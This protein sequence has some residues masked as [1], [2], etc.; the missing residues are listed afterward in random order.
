MKHRI[1]ADNVKKVIA[2]KDMDDNFL[3]KKV[4]NEQIL[5]GWKGLVNEIAE[6]W[7]TDH[8]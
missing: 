5:L 3:A 2:L 4:Y 7:S 1:W 6:I 8:S